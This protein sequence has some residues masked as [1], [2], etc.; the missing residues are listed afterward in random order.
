MT[1]ASAQVTVTPFDAA[2]PFVVSAILMF[3]G[4]FSGLAIEKRLAQEFVE[5]GV[6]TES[7]TAAT[8]A[9]TAG[10]TIDAAQV[11]TMFLTPF[12]GLLLLKPDLGSALSLL[13]LGSFVVSLCGFLG[14]TYLVPIARYGPPRHIPL[15]APVSLIGIVVNLVAA[16]AAALIVH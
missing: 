8:L 16:G 4:P 6:G 1:L 3:I 10:W 15:F 7:Y 5:W 11:I 9:K 14:F 2:V 12:M 13:Y